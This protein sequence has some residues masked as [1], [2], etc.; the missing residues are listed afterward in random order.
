[1]RSGAR[2]EAGWFAKVWLAVWLAKD[3]FAKVGL[4]KD[5]LAKV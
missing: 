2:F 3:W 1:V 4:A 5:W